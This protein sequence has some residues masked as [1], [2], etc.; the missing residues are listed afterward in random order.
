[1]SDFICETEPNSKGVSAQNLWRMK[2]FFETYS[3]D[4]KL[5]QMARDI[6]WTNNM[7]IIS[8]TKSAEEREFY[9]KLTLR[10]GYSKSELQRQLDSGLYERSM[11]T[12]E[13]LS[14]VVR[15][16]YPQVKNYIKDY[17]SLEFLGLESGFNEHSFQKAIL[18][19]LK[20]FILEFGKDFLFIEEEYRIQVGNSDSFV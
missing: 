12:H 4:E 20:Q 15:D 17:Y 6:C 14:P 19:N 3:S 8:Q 11:L 9:L 1:M 5:S 13:N 2:Q 10:E 16:L 18:E 7:I